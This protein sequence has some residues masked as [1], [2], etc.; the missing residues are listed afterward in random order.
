VTTLTVIEDLDVAGDAGAKFAHVGKDV[1]VDV[2]V[3]EDRPEAL[4][5]GLVL[6]RAG[7]TH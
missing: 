5:A 1:A 3:L 7:L 2:L 6:A 4:G